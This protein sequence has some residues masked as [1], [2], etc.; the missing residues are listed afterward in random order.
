M[1]GRLQ[2]PLHRGEGGQFLRKKDDNRGLHTTPGMPQPRADHLESVS[3][4]AREAMRFQ[5]ERFSQ[6]TNDVVDLLDSALE[7]SIAGKQ[8]ILSVL[9]TYMEV[10]FGNIKAHTKTMWGHVDQK[11]EQV[12]T[13]SEVR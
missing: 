1:H 12:P 8:N 6:M 3:V 9:T 11:I 2:N 10:Q 7:D 5:E 4:M 13:A